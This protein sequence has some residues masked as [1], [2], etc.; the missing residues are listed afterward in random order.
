M[1]EIR[2][3]VLVV[4]GLDTVLENVLFNLTYFSPKQ[5]KNAKVYLMLHKR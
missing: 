4:C 5:D 2:C 1:D 3:V